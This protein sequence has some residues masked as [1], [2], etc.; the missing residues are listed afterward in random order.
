MKWQHKAIEK[1]K[2][3]VVAD[4]CLCVVVFCDCVCGCDL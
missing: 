2:N 1:I 4:V 3:I